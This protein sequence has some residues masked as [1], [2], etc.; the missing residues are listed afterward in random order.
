MLAALLE[1]RD[2]WLHRPGHW[3]PVDLRPRLDALERLR[4]DQRTPD[5][6]PARL[7][8][9][10]RAA[11]QLQ[12]LVAGAGPS[13]P[14]PHPQPQP[15]PAIDERQSGQRAS[16]GTLL[17]LAYPERVARR[18]EGPEGVRGGVRY[19]LRNGTGA[20]L[21]RDD[22]LATEPWLIIADLEAAQGDHRIRAAAAISEAEVCDLFAGE[23]RETRT[24]SWDGQREALV[25]RRERRLGAIL[26]DAQPEP[27]GAPDEGLPL[28]LSAIAREPER[29]LH[30]TPATRQ[31]SARTEL[32]R[33]LQPE[34]DWPDLSP[35][36]LSASLQAAVEADSS[37]EHWLA[38]WLAGISS[39]AAVRALDLGEVLR[40]RL[41]WARA[42]ALD[43][44]A[45]ARLRTPAGTE[46]PIDYSAGVQPVLQVP[47]Q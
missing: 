1:E 37:A 34:A 11:T 8:A 5:F 21:P 28:L 40:G 13:K 32:A 44:L 6:D 33:R 45:P 17:A 22:T 35:V 36:G 42:Q 25:A 47:L 3:R 41:G 27:L 14:Q 23:V 2:P 30:W 43:S 4:H 38:P 16:L 31:L 15:G 12:R 46:R 18:R 24:L 7:R 20:E 19:L 9:V 29:A 39:L 26:L 10:Q